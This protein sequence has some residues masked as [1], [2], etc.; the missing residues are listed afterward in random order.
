MRRFRVV[1]RITQF[2]EAESAEDASKYVD[3]LIKHG[4]LTL[5]KDG[6]TIVRFSRKD[7]VVYKEAPE[8]ISKTRSPIEKPRPQDWVEIEEHGMK[9][10]ALVTRLSKRRI[11]FLD[12]LTKLERSLDKDQWMVWAKQHRVHARYEHVLPPFI[13]GEAMQ[14]HRDKGLLGEG[15]AQTDSSIILAVLEKYGYTPNDYEMKNGYW[16]ENEMEKAISMHI[17]QKAEDDEKE[18][19]RKQ[20][21]ESE[22]AAPDLKEPEASSDSEDSSTTDK[23]SSR[24]ASTPQLAP[25]AKEKSNDTLDYNDLPDIPDLSW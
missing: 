19:L 16:A 23:P 1:T 8:D 6:E 21:Q 3:E 14:T 22:K 15:L 18:M 10:I 24:P 25:A 4:E 9:T 13:I 2:I 5:D 11:Y 7:D 12:G 17:L 20:L